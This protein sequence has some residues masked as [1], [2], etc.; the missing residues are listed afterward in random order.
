MLHLRYV[1]DTDPH[2]NGLN[3]TT[4]RPTRGE[5][6][7]KSEFTHTMRHTPKPFIAA[8]L[9]GRHKKDVTMFSHTIADMLG[10]ALCY[11]LRNSSIQYVPLVVGSVNPPSQISPRT[12][13]LLSQISSLLRSNK[14]TFNQTHHHH[15][16][17]NYRHND[18]DNHHGNHS[19]HSFVSSSQLIWR[20]VHATRCTPPPQ[21]NTHPSQPNT[22]PPNSFTRQSSIDATPPSLNTH[23][24]SINYNPD[25]HRFEEMDLNKPGLVDPLALSLVHEERKN[26]LQHCV[27]TYLFI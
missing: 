22:H 9:G 23:P 3:D 8:H 7:N 21:S 5:L 6:L 11:R 20:R 2:W 19:L 26:R 10:K 17:H 24:P 15:H 14:S 1:H 4:Y 25:M 18:T 16:H 13:Q 27:H 12:V